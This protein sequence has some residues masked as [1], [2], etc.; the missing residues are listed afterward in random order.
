[1]KYLA[2]VYGNQ[3]TWE[4]FPAEAGPETI[5]EQEAFNAEYRESGELLG[6]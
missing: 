1:M 6:T 3:V 5:A 2:T 4:A